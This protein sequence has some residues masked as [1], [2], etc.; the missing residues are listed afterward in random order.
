MAFNFLGG[1]VSTAHPAFA[2][3]FPSIY[4]TCKIKTIPCLGQIVELKCLRRDF[5]SISLHFYLL[6]R[7]MLHFISRHQL[8]TCSSCSYPSSFTQLSH[9]PLLLLRL[10]NRKRC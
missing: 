1:L 6:H 10:T 4:S 7:A 3:L 8:Y 2:T 5:R 9:L